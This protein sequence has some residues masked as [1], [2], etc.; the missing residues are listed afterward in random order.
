MADERSSELE[1][2]LKQIAGDRQ[3]DPVDRAIAEHILA[4]LP[5]IHAI[6]RKGYGELRV[7]FIDRVVFQVEETHKRRV[8]KAS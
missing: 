7:T 1:T 6:H 2:T 3:A 4:M 5:E 8:P